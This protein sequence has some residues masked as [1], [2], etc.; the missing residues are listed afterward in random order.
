M[1]VLTLLLSHVVLILVFNSLLC[2]SPLYYTMSV[3]YVC[4]APW[5]HSNE[6][7]DF[8]DYISSRLFRANNVG[9][10]VIY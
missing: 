7:F 2:S 1:L 9:M 6:L 8:F 5:A 4:Y 10:T 3:I